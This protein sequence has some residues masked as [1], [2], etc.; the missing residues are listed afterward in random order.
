MT[1]LEQYYKILKI[2]SGSSVEEIKKAYRQ[3]AKKWHPDNFNDSPEKA[4][5]AEAKFLEIHEAYE[6]LK[7]HGETQ[8][9]DGQDG[10]ENQKKSSTFIRKNLDTNEKKAEFYYQ[11]GVE[12]A[13]NEQWEEAVKYFSHVI[14]L[15]EH[16]INAYF[17]RGAMLDKLGLKLRAESDWKQAEF[18]KS[19]RDNRV[20]FYEQN[21]SYKGKTSTG[22]R[23]KRKN[24]E[25]S[26]KSS[27]SLNGLVMAGFGLVIIALSLALVNQN[28]NSS[29]NNQGFLPSLNGSIF[30]LSVDG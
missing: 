30:L 16:F 21:G 23:Q 1:G 29:N 8:K 7:N 22:Y 4:E 15:D 9:V 19:I 24:Y 10:N 11:L 6:I 27:S 17:Y 18:L 25:A 2:E 13:E 5:L 20:E 26:K 28:R 3:L 12:E 14:K